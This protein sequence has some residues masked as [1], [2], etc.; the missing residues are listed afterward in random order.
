M[1]E[2]VEATFAIDDMQPSGGGRPAV[3]R[4]VHYRDP[5][6][7]RPDAVVP[8]VFVAAID[9]SSRILL[10]RR[11]DS[12]RWELPGGRV[13]VGESA[14]SAARRETAEES[15]VLVRIT[16]LVGVY[17]EPEHIVVAV[18]GTVRQQFV[19]VFLAQ[20]T[21]GQPRGDQGETCAAE[22]FEAAAL[23]NLPVD[24]PVRRWIADALRGDPSPYL[25]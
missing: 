24:L 16:G 10:V 5:N 7:P 17:T 12:G 4:V 9:S 1:N 19:L 2:S 8:S 13:D 20:V 22:W 15:G 11:C 25:S 3:G 14:L 6:A 21:G 23:A 18:D